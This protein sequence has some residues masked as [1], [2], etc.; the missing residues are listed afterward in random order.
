[1]SSAFTI[2]LIRRTLSRNMKRPLQN[3]VMIFSTEESG[4]YCTHD[5]VASKYQQ[6]PRPQISLN[7][8]PFAV[9]R[10]GSGGGGMCPW[11][12]FQGINPATS[13]CVHEGFLD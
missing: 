2:Q 7:K 13:S 5:R 8:N 3:S 1:M 10:S 4:F 9:F 6:T 11:I 12:A